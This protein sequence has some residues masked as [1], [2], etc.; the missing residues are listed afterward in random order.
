MRIA[1]P[2]DPGLKTASEVATIEF[3]R[4]ETDMP[5]PNTLAF[6]C[7][8]QN[9]LGFEWVLMEY[10]RGRPLESGWRDIPMSKKAEISESARYALGAMVE[11]AFF[12]GDRGHQRLAR[13]PFKNSYEWLLTRLSLVI[14]EKAKILATTKDKDAM[15]DAEDSKSIAAQ[16]VHILP[17][18]IPPEDNE[19]SIIVHNDLS[20]N[21][22][23]INDAGDPIAVVDWECV[24]ALPLL[25]ACQ[26]PQLLTGTIQH[27][28]P[29]I[30]EYGIGDLY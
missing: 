28:K 24:S 11:V 26:Y 6:D 10:V 5:L 4:Q 25:R 27:R 18:I 20:T 29:D 19:Q 16:L 17:S 22:I 7:S 15:E 3:V 14:E 23:L 9:I 13:G 2:V 12:W 1:L 21:N 30:E 8:N